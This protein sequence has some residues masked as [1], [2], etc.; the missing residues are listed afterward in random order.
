MYKRQVQVGPKGQFVYRIE[1]DGR[2]SSQPITDEYLTSDLAV[3]DGLDG[4]SRIV[5]EGGQNLRPGLHVTVI[6][7]DAAR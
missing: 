1:P 6:Q 3:V 7:D 2:V 5:T 4:G